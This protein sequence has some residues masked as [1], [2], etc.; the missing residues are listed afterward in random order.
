MLDEL[1]EFFRYT[2]QET[3]EIFISIIFMAFIFSFLPLSL[4]FGNVL[5]VLTSSLIITGI[6]F[7]IHVSLQK[8]ISVL[9][10]YVATYKYW[11]IGLLFSLI[12]AF[13]SMGTLPLVLPGVIE[14]DIVERLRLGK[15]PY[16]INYG[17]LAFI[18]LAGPMS[19]IFIAFLLK[20][21]YIITN[22]SLFKYAIIINLLIAVF[23]LLPLPHNTGLNIFMNSRLLFYVSFFTVLLYSVL[24]W[25]GNIW[26]L[27]GA[28]SL[29]VIVSFF[30]Y[31]K[32]K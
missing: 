7:F 32:T 20:P 6:S 25:Y 18:S 27:F 14:I 4:G 15:F 30:I 24:I 23:T 19:N 9:R 1:R 21:L 26:A 16:G 5:F 28:F 13:V 8:A 2:N 22:S 10:G 3:K 12:T 17:E 11:L 29:S 31:S